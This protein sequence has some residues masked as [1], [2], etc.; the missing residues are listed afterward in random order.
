MKPGRAPRCQRFGLIGPRRPV[1]Q[2]SLNQQLVASRLIE[3]G[4]AQLPQRAHYIGVAVS[5]S[6]ETG[7]ALVPCAMGRQSRRLRRPPA[8][9]DGARDEAQVYRRRVFG[10]CG[11]HSLAVSHSELALLK[12]GL[13]KTKGATEPQQGDAA[14]RL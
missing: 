5:R 3:V 2:G 8:N 4:N 11:R 12:S 6:A 13:P 7:A 9:L 1:D 14:L 10:G